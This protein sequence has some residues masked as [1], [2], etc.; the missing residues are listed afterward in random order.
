LRS[1]PSQLTETEESLPKE[2][3][4]IPKTK[5]YTWLKKK[6]KIRIPKGPDAPVRAKK[7]SQLY[8][9]HKR[10][11]YTQQ[12]PELSYGDITKQL[13]QMYKGL[14]PGQQK[15]Y[16]KSAR[17]DRERYKR[18][19]KNYMQTHKEDNSQ[20]NKKRKRE[21]Y[22][23]KGPKQPELIFRE[24]KL[25]EFIAKFPRLT[26]K[27]VNR[28]INRA[29]NELEYNKKLPYIEKS[30]QE[31]QLYEEKKKKFSLKKQHQNEAESE[32]RPSKRR[33]SNK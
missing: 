16:I 31:I 22:E 10:T 24:E 28:E 18:E 19:V 8:A 21:P 12:H 17:I 23:P 26:P 33:K 25:L 1:D 4:P 5:S 7:P 13:R 15:Q 20:G 29:W 14:Q 2:E 32:E 3:S 27:E 6:K 30:K 9:E 11:K